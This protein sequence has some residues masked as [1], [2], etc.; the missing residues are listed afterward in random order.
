LLGDMRR[1]PSLGALAAAVGLS[2][3]RLNAAF[4][5]CFGGTVFETL[6]NER[7]AHAR[8]A[9]KTEPIPL[10]QVA[11]R[12]GYNHVTNF[13]NAFS[14]RYGEPPRRYAAESIRRRPPSLLDGEH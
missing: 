12:V 5:A 4:R 10:K 9:L 6:R 13:I 2:E 7:L 1:P 8:L 14:A 11:F 3:K